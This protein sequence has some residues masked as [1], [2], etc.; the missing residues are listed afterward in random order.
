[1]FARADGS[2]LDP[3]VLSQQFEAATRRAS[4]KRIRFHDLRHTHASL[5]L[6]TGIYAKVMQ[7]QLGHS[8]IAVILNTYGHVVPALQEEAAAKIA[9]V[10]DGIRG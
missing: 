1:V 2:A 8:S 3:D 7:E 4:L 6:A 5:A 10:V 9:A